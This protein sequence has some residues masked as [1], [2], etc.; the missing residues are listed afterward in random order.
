[1]PTELA[2]R[3][4]IWKRRVASGAFCHCFLPSAARRIDLY[5]PRPRHA[6][7]LKTSASCLALELVELHE[8]FDRGEAGDVQGFQLLED[9][10]FF[11]FE[12]GELYLLLRGGN[13]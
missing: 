8:G 3:G 5:A 2:M 12:E 10:V 6:L 4:S 11:R 1:G 7:Q 13:G 9:R